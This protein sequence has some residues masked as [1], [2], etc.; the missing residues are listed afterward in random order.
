MQNKERLAT[1]SIFKLIQEAY[2]KY[3]QNYKIIRCKYL[4]TDVTTTLKQH[5]VVTDYYLK[6][7][8]RGIEETLNHLKRTLYFSY[9]KQKIT[10]II[11]QCDICQKLKYDRRPPKPIYQKTEIPEV[12]LQIVHMDIYTINGQTILTLIDKFSKHASAYTLVEKT[13]SEIKYTFI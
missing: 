7:N 4:L 10:Q 8:H 11:N 1:D 13:R 12:P 9:M 5:S 6:N 2:L 3:F